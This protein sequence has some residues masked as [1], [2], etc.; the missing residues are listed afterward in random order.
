MTEMWLVGW[1]VEI[2]D[3]KA[4]VTESIDFPIYYQT[5]LKRTELKTRI[6]IASLSHFDCQDLCSEGDF[7][8]MGKLEPSSIPHGV[9]WSWLRDIK[10]A[11]YTQGFQIILYHQWYFK[12]FELFAVYYRQDSTVLLQN[13]KS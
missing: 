12:G 7:V 13:S 1:L 5:L 4:H 6:W 3:L 2:A 8:N 11:E 10:T 9:V